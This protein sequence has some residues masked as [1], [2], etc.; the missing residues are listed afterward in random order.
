[1]A[2]P[3]PD[4]ASTW[5]GKTIVDRQG[6]TIGACVQVYTDDATGL[7]EWAAARMGSASVLLPLVD[8]V[9][10]HGMVR[11]AVDRDEVV[12]APAVADPHH[13][14]SDEEAGLYRHFDIPFS[15]D[16]S[17][18]LLPSGEGEPPGRDRQPAADIGHNDS[19]DPARGR[20][21]LLG[22]LTAAAVGVLGVRSLLARRHR[23]SAS[24]APPGEQ[25]TPDVR[26]TA[27]RRTCGN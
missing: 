18:T 19:R 10:D 21:L 24:P 13:I 14:T 17:R 8:A 27:H 6:A 3:D 11:V 9:E 25:G 1:M 22:A 15:R 12:L 2:M 16:R 23:Q 26:R 20:A 4:Q 7:P 5:A